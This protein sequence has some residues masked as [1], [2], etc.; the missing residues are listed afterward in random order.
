MDIQVT[1]LGI[2]IVVKDAQQ[3]FIK[4]ADPGAKNTTADIMKYGDKN[5]VRVKVITDEFRGNEQE[6]IENMI[7]GFNKIMDNF[8][9]ENPPA[10]AKPTLKLVK[11][12]GEVQNGKT[13]LKPSN[14]SNPL[15]SV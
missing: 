4:V 15:S 3:Y 6:Y 1:P 2:I 14:D 9:K 10:E 12:P 11:K 7:D 5:F 8:K 13:I